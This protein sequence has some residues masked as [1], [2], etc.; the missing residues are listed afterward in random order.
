MPISAKRKLVAGATGLAV[1]AGSGGAYAASQSSTPTTTKPAAAV[2]RAAETT[3]FLDDV[4]KRLNV[5]RD[6]LDAAIKGAAEARI[7]AAVA[8]RRLT[9]EQ[10]EA[11]KKRLASGLPALGAG[12]IL[13][14]GPRAGKPGH[15]IMGLGFRLDAAADYLGLTAAQ[16]REQLRDGKSLADVAKAQNKSVDGLKA[17]LKSALTAELDQAVKDKKLT[18]A[19]KTRILANAD[20]RIDAIVENTRPRGGPREFKRRWR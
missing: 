17:A 7:D 9:K 20:A 5:T 16:L 3:A 12:R 11:A 2:D 4:A 13:G 15:R 10:G 8:D 19:Q 14:G 18:E 1:L 6:Q